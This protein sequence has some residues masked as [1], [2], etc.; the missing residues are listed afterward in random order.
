MIG[1]TSEGSP[2]S[3][4]YNA[5]VRQSDYLLNDVPRWPNGAISH[6]E[7]HP[8]LW[9]DFTYMVPPFLAYHGV[10]SNNLDLLKQAADQCAKYQ[11]VLGTNEGPW[12]HISGRE[13]PNSGG[14]TR[15]PRMWSSGNGWATAGMARVIATMRK[16][17]FDSQTDSEQNMLTQLIK[18][19]VDGARHFDTEGQDQMRLLRNYLD[20]GY[21]EI[22]GTAMIAAATLRMAVLEPGVFGKEYTDWAV[23]KVQVV[24][25]HILDSGIVGPAVNPWNWWSDD[26]NDAYWGGSPEGQSFTVLMH[27]AYRDWAGQGN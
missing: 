21:P 4:Y 2:N 1:Q 27:A 3:H 18:Q 9:S 13:Q 23:K 15:D 19:I 12:R 11:Q 16:S 10:V 7:T 8:E 26:P 6:R 14:E 17:G 22:A 24:D 5:A 25:A 20:S